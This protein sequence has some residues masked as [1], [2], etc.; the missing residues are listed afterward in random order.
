MSAQF[1]WLQI[2]AKEELIIPVV[3]ASMET[4]RMAKAKGTAR[5]LA[6]MAMI[7]AR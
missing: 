4:L 6:G 7:G 1:V 3:S 5:I 2:M